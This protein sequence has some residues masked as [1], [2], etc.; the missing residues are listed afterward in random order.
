MHGEYGLEHGWLMLK[1]PLVLTSTTSGDY[2]LYF[3]VFKKYN[4]QDNT[5]PVA[6]TAN[7]FFAR[8]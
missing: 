7:D 3:G 2:T 8:S 4:H 1:R 5:Y 6:T